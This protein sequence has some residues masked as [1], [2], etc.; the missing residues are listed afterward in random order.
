MQSIDQIQHTFVQIFRIVNV[1]K[2]RLLEY[3]SII[4]AKLRPVLGVCSLPSYRSEHARGG[5]AA[6]LAA[7][8]HTLGC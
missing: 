2:S 7:P 6:D 4:T 8:H 5:P 3:F 1:A